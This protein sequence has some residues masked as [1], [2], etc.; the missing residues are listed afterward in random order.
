MMEELFAER[1]VNVPRSFIREILKVSLDPEIISFAGG[2]PNRDYFPVEEIQ[3]ATEE[4]FRNS[5]REILQY[6]NSEGLLGLREYIAKRYR[7]KK[8]L[9]VSPEDILIT[10]GSQQG[11][12]LLAKALI[13]TGDAVL[14][15]EPGYLGAIQSLSIFRPTFLPI[16]LGD[17]GMDIDILRDNCAGRKIKF[18]YAVPNFQNP[19]GLTYSAD[20]RRQIAEIA[21][22][23]GF[24]LVEDDPYGELRFAGQQ[25]PS[26][27]SFLP[28]Q[29]VLLG[30]FSKIVAPGLRLGWIVA[31]KK[32]M[33][34]LLVA[35]QAADLHTSGFA[36][37]ILCRYLQDND[38]D[39]HI[40]RIIEAYGSQCRSMLASLDRHLP[41]DISWTR[42]EGGMFLW[43][44]LPGEMSSMRL[45]DCAVRQ[46]VVFVPGDPFYVTKTQVPTLRL[47]FSCSDAETIEQGVLR[48]ARALAEMRG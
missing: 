27:Y 16:P 1:I 9:I 38:I 28:K 2:L 3:A 44:K 43:G 21:A 4:V 36:Q 24:L 23:G 18:M 5:G 12:D 29:T 37:H 47:N 22:A 25:Q 33:D 35:K 46:K 14:L 15:E 41:A 11:L 7:E 8:G 13:N 39:R 48:L 19:S 10:N 40:V 31:P 30:S 17:E 26:F 20:N 34:K 32:I 42:P 45:F 6:S